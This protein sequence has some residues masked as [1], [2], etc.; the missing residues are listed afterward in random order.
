MPI[1]CALYVYVSVG[2]GALVN[3]EVSVNQSIQKNG[4]RIA[5]HQ[6]TPGSSPFALCAALAAER[7]AQQAACRERFHGQFTPPRLSDEIYA[8]IPAR[9]AL[10]RPQIQA[11]IAAA[12]AL[13]GNRGPPTKY[14]SRGIGYISLRDACPKYFTLSSTNRRVSAATLGLDGLP[15]IRRQG[16]TA[17]APRIRTSC[18]SACPRRPP[19]LP[20]DRRQRPAPRHPLRPAFPRC[21]QQRG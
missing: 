15:R 11:Q 3:D 5:A 4:S 8:A 7:G 21:R 19:R 14:T 6:R 18:C 13:T 1:T 9:Y 20:A 2:L 17:S 12:T 10:E 16:R